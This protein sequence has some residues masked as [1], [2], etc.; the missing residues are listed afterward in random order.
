MAENAQEPPNCDRIEAIAGGLSPE[1]PGTSLWVHG[2]PGSGRA[3]LISAAFDRIPG[4]PTTQ[5]FRCLPES[6]LEETLEQIALVLEQAG[7][8]TL[9]TALSQRTSLAAK[10]NVCFEALRDTPVILWLEDFDE[11]GREWGNEQTELISQFLSGCTGLAGSAGRV[12]V[13]SVDCPPCGGFHEVRVESSTPS[14]A[15]AD[16]ADWHRHPFALSVLN[17]SVER[18]NPEQRSEFLRSEA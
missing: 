10:V 18:F 7:T 1:S 9:S 3:A 15:S 17:R 14:V 5:R 8:T 16:A 6:C 2:A 13:V 11:L 12:L 4:N